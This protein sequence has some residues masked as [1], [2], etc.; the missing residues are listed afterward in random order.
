MHMAN[1]FILHGYFLLTYIGHIVAGGW[2]TL[3][4]VD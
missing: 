2:H 4:N 3:T 1:A